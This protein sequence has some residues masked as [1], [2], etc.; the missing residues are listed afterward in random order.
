MQT[1]LICWLTIGV[2]SISYLQ[3]RLQSR[4]SD[5]IVWTNTISP[6]IHQSIRIAHALFH[7]S[8]QDIRTYFSDT[9]AAE[10]TTI[11]ITH[12]HDSTNTCHSLALSACNNP[13]RNDFNRHSPLL[14]WAQRRSESYQ[15]SNVKITHTRLNGLGVTLVAG[16]GRTFPWKRRGRTH[17]RIVLL[18]SF[19][20]PTLLSTTF[21]EF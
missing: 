10:S 17:N 12:R 14:S 7:N 1:V 6:I 20:S 15:I 5:L 19:V 9:T 8:H 21:T 3:G 11:T 18:S 2:F 4:N 13:A 16:P